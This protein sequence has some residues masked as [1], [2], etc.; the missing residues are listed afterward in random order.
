VTH[1]IVL[2]VDKIPLSIKHMLHVQPAVL[3]RIFCIYC[4][5]K[6]LIPYSAPNTKVNMSSS[7]AKVAKKAFDPSDTDSYSA[8]LDSPVVMLGMSTPKTPPAGSPRGRTHPISSSSSFSS[9]TPLYGIYSLKEGDL[10]DDPDTAGSSSSSSPPHEKAAEVVMMA[11]SAK[12]WKKLLD[13]EGLWQLLKDFNIC[14]HL[15][16]KLKI[17]EYFSKLLKGSSPPLPDRSSPAPQ[18]D[19]KRTSSLLR[20]FMSP[21]GKVRYKVS[22]LT[23]TSV[24]SQSGGGASSAELISFRCFHQFL[25]QL[26]VK[27]LVGED[28]LLQLDEA[29]YG[30]LVAAV[31]DLLPYAQKQSLAFTKT[32]DK[33]IASLSRIHQDKAHH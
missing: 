27:Y 10:E 30:R 31:R 24:P 33:Q 13:V 1:L 26:P 18:S 14:P 3:W 2:I 12:E 9:S 23:S 6:K 25:W 22:S 21:D 5:D 4:P 16:S 19:S 28:V 29:A 8:E 32:L 15:Y 11:A 20:D 7:K 17:K